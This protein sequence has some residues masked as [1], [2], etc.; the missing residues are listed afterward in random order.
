MLPS[1]AD[2]GVAWGKLFRQG[3]VKPD[4]RFAKGGT[5]RLRKLMRQEKR[6]QSESLSPEGVEQ[7][8]K[9]KRSELWRILT[10]GRARGVRAWGSAMA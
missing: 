2:Q 1:S 10:I 9:K 5:R 6:S 3:V 8:L 7:E 4:Q